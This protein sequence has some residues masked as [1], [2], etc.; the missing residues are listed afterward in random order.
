MTPFAIML[1]RY[2]Q[3]DPAQAR[4]WWHA[5]GRARWSVVQHWRRALVLFDQGV[6]PSLGPQQKIDAV[7]RFLE[8]QAS[9]VAVVGVLEALRQEQ[10]L[11]RDEV[12]A[13]EAKVLE[14]VD[15][16]GRWK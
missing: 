15:K 10:V 4:R 2:W 5:L 11:R 14:Q 7:Q 12:L 16:D 8:T 13:I 1:T 6:A 9:P 3:L